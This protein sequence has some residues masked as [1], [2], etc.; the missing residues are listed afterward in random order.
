LSPVEAFIETPSGAPRK[1]IE[2]P[3]DGG[4]EGRFACQLT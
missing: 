4:R 1:Y 2:W 3:M